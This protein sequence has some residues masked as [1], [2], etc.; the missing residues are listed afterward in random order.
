MTLLLRPRST[1]STPTLRGPWGVK[2]IVNLVPKSEKHDLEWWLAHI[3][4]H[5]EAGG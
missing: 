5:W 4:T 1:S 2:K 3:A